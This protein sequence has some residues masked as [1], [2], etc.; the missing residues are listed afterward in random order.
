MVLL[1]SPL[2]SFSCHFSRCAA[3][4]R[5]PHTPPRAVCRGRGR[6]SVAQLDDVRPPPLA[7]AKLR[8]STAC[9]GWPHVPP[10]LPGSGPRPRAFIARL[11]AVALHSLLLFCSPGRGVAGAALAAAAHRGQSARPSA[12]RGA[13]PHALLLLCSG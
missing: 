11:V 6:A 7:G 2:P 8:P 3:A 12:A 9:R 13:A 1:L 5:R 4:H 10:L